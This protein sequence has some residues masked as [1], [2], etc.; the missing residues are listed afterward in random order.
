MIINI[1][2][3][4]VA[5]IAVAL[6]V[7]LGIAIIWIIRAAR[8]MKALSKEHEEMKARVDQ[9]LSRRGTP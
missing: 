5:C 2:L 3:G 7:Y 9:R 4:I 8:S 1:L 6:L